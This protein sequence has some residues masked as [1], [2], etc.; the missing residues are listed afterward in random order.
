[1]SKYTVEVKLEAVERYLTGNQSYKTIAES[2][3]AAKSQVIT[4]VKLFE[5]QGEHGF[6]KDDYTSYS[7]AFKLDVLNFMI[8]TGASLRETASTF[9]ISSP[10]TVYKWE[11]LLKTKGMDALEPKKK[12]RP[13]MKKETKK[14][15][16]PTFTPAEDSVEALQAKV[17]RLEMENAYLK[18]LNALVQTQE[19]ITNK[20][21]AQVIFELKGQ[22]EVVDLVEVA[23]IPRSTYYYWEK[24]LDQ[25]DKY[26]AGKEA[27]KIIYHEHKGRYG[28]RR[29]AKELQKY[30]FTH[31]PKTINRLMNEIGLKC[32]VRMKKYRSY[33]GNVG[34]IAP[35]VLQRDFKAEKMNQKWVTDVTEFHLFGEKRYLSPVLDLCNGEIIAYK[36]MNRPVYQLVGDMLDEAVQRLQP[37][38]EV[39]LHS[40]Q[41]WH[42]Q[43]KKY[44]QTLQAHQITQSMSRKGNCLDNAV[45]ENFFGLLKSELLY[46]QEFESMA[47]FEKELEEYMDYYNHKRMKAKLKDLSPV[48]YRT[49]ILEAA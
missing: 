41:G 9:N 43:M 7:S 47:H 46:L 42:Y 25:V 28:Y 29:I 26:E 3:G 40:D 23:D 14:I 27:I 22:Y 30:G 32:E 49:Q 17:E 45:I 10:S 44:Q 1:M 38:D 4:W 19:K 31:D 18:K 5:A 16:S 34:K 2:I 20:I 6:Q 21:K 39:I 13:S 33:K 37:G 24:R 8:K 12:G 36:V 11:Q 35:N 15:I 48:E